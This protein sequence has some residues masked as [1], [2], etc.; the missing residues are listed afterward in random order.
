[1][2]W[3]QRDSCTL[4]T[5]IIFRPPSSLPQLSEI[6]RL[7]YPLCTTSLSTRATHNLSS[8]SI[9]FLSLFSFS[10]SLICQSFSPSPSGLCLLIYA[11][12]LGVCLFCL[13]YLFICIHLLSLTVSAGR[14]TAITPW[15]LTWLAIH[16]MCFNRVCEQSN[17]SG[18]VEYCSIV[19]NQSSLGD[20]SKLHLY[21]SGC[22]LWLRVIVFS[23]LSTV[24]KI[25][26]LEKCWLFEKLLV[27]GGGGTKNWE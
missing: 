15:P 16:P 25:Q 22:S 20:Q 1:M 6:K 18:P 19:S 27:N 12:S 23:Q 4:A 8:E 21:S 7:C 3:K 2:S 14:N 17:L 26:R 24:S 5:N 13:L 10:Q 9:D 11:H